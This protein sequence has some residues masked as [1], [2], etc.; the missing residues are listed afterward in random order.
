M[1]NKYLPVAAAVLLVVLLG[2]LTDPLMFW[3]PEPAQMVALLCAAVLA[4][5]WAGL[6]LYEKS[7]DER[8]AAHAMHA[9]R[10]AYL[11]GIAVLT[12]A[13]VAQGLAHDIDPWVTFALGT[14]VVAKLIARWHAEHYR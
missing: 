9:G 6:V 5:L 10:V 2:L 11:S 3:M 4:A 14:M 1:A 12:V 13:L 7:N 8:E